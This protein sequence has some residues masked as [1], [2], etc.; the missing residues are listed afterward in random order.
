MK[1]YLFVISLVWFLGAQAA[2]TQTEGSFSQGM[3]S[4]SSLSEGTQTLSTQISIPKWKT[5]FTSYYYNF[6]G[7][8]DQKND[9]Y[10]FGLT[11]LKM[12]MMSLQYQTE[13][14]WTLMGLAQYYETYVETK[15]YG[16]T[17]KDSSRGLADTLLAASKPMVMNGPFMLIGDLGV[18]LPTGSIHEMNP[19]S[20]VAGVHYPYNMQMGSGTVDSVWGL[21]S[22]YLE[23]SYQLGARASAV[24]RGD[25]K[26]DS[27]YHLGNLYRVDGWLDVPTRLGLTPR[28]VGY[29]KNKKGVVGADNTFGRNSFVEYYHHDQ[30]DWNMSAALK[31]NYSYTPQLALTAEAGVPFYQGCQNYDNVVVYT[32]YYANL[33]FTGQF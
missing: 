26:N 4:K 21:T 30:I 12:Q 23:P 11:T 10:G 28:I 33:G 14:G 19:N 20:T 18:S 3:G 27:G 8:K 16:I 24:V 9:L 5:N 25:Y 7:V 6:E 13:S 2:A 15:M 22:L 1:L 29:Y 31:Y 32:R 17:Y